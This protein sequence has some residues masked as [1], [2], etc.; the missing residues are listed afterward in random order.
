MAD[1]DGMKLD[2]DAR[3]RLRDS[4]AHWERIATDTRLPKETIFAKDC[5]LCRRFVDLRCV[6]C[7][8]E[9][10]KEGRPWNRVLGATARHG[11]DS[12]EFFAAAQ[13]MLDFLRQLDAEAED[14]STEAQS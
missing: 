9:S 6:G 8:V 7:P 11:H 2:A 14:E 5:A 10:C 12:P 4:I 13:A 1:G 3:K